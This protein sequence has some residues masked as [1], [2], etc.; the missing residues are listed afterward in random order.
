MDC[1]LI[2]GDLIAY[3]FAAATD[4]ERARVEAHLVECT[5]CLRAYLALKAHIDR[6]GDGQVGPSE[7]SRVRLRLAVADRFRP[8][9]LRR[10]R[11]W[12]ARPIPLYQG[13]AFAAG[14]ILAATLVPSLARRSVP[15]TTADISHRVDT[16][17]S[18]AESLSIY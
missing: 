17:R 15:G 4:D 10:V 11:R 2:Q 12:L 14:L 8:T 9:P 6:V 5:S 1:S 18:T 16:S 3:H 7:P 13:L